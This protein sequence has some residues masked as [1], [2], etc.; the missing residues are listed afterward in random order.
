MSRG[1]ALVGSAIKG[2]SL[3]GVNL[4]HFINLNNFARDLKQALYYYAGPPGGHN[5]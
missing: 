1:E 5:W 4:N 3:A 2:A